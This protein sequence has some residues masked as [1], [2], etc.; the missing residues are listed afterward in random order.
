MP[1]FATLKSK[2][3]ADITTV[4]PMLRPSHLPGLD[5]LRAVAIIIVLI[6]HYTIN[7]RYE[8]VL[9]GDI[10]VEIFFVISG[11]LI[12]SLLLKEQV[13]KGSISLKYFYIRR[14]LRIIPV[15][16]LF[17]LTVYV[18]NRYLNLGVSLRSIILA[19]LFTT[20]I[21]I[22][23]FRAHSWYVGHFWSLSVEEQFYLTFP[24]L[25][26]YN[27]NRYLKVVI[28][29]I[30]LVPIIGYLGFNNVGVFYTNRAVHVGALV[31]IDLLE[32][33]FASSLARYYLSCFL[34]VS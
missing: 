5:G 16:Y 17:L 1:G 19:G 13:N 33:R 32:K 34:K 22:P 7:T 21:G 9:G 23:G 29:L 27:L 2:L 18:L 12:T 8:G 24:F 10:G 31:I 6:S 26:A 4:P 11:F 20:N 28:V 15:A 3:F 25:L 30:I 14:F